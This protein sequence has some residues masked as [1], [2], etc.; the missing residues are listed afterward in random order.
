MRHNHLV[1]LALVLAV[2]AGAQTPPLSPRQA[3]ALARLHS[4][5]LPVASSR[6]RIAAGTPPERA[7]APN[8]VLELRQE[9]LGGVIVADRFATVTLPLDMTFQRAALRTAGRQSVAASVADSAATAQQVD[10]VVGTLYWRAAL[11]DGIAE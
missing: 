7:A 2:P 3:L 9:I 1:V 5:L 8:P 4:P 6:V 11:A 10:A